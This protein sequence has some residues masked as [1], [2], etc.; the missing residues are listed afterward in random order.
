MSSSWQ[1]PRE[2]GSSQ[3]LVSRL[4]QENDVE[5]L[6]CLA[7][8]GEVDLGACAP[9]SGVTA[10]FLAIE[11]DRPAILAR[12]SDCMCSKRSHRAHGMNDSTN[13]TCCLCV[14]AVTHEAVL[15]EFDVDLSKPCDPMGY[16]SAA[17]WAAKKAREDCLL[18]LFNVSAPACEPPMMKP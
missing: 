15:Q 18:E 4:V 9:G 1:P 5:M 2:G 17:F 3:A 12:E 11:Y 16:G 8:T 14:R 13:L 6:R 7:K 10:A